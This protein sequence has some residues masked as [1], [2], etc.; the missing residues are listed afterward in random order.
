MLRLKCAVL[1]GI[2]T[3]SPFERVV[4]LWEII[5]VKASSNQPFRHKS[6]R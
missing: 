4:C 1:R 2:S 6:F 5:L 3:H